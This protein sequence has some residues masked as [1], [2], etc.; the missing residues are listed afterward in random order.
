MCLVGLMPCLPV[1]CTQ[2][3]QAGNQVLLRAGHLCQAWAE[4]V[5]DVMWLSGLPSQQNWN[6]PSSSP[7]QSKAW[8]DYL[9]G[10]PLRTFTL[11]GVLSMSSGNPGRTNYFL[12]APGKSLDT[13]R[14]LLGTE[15][16][17]AGISPCTQPIVWS[18]DTAGHKSAGAETLS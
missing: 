5:P 6:P 2:P 18:R 9:W 14:R 1:L 10:S 8:A 11:G 4:Y 13:W 3:P 12:C 17:K 15:I 7:W 16:L